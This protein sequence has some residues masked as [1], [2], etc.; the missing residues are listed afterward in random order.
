M[1]VRVADRVLV[2]AARAGDVEAFEV[3][4]RRHQGG[5]YRV[6]VRLLGSDADAQDATQE[7]F[8]RAWRG[9]GRF[10]GESAVSTW[11]YRIVTN[12]CL[13]VIVARRP[14]ESLDPAL[15]SVGSDPAAIAEQRER[16]AAVAREVAS[17]P[18]EQR[19]AL[20][21]RDFEGLSYEE[22]AAA[23]EV[24]VAAVKGRIHRARLSVLKETTAW[25]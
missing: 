25:H 14:A 18:P 11:L 12:R 4:V 21:L 6:A 5:V 24:S 23:L 16:F 7:T 19:A 13:N 22:V 15:P 10:R 17:L 20:V 2:D 3:L 1:V 8:V 9:L